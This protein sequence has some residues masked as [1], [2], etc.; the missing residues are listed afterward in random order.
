M[1]A[2][3]AFAQ[4]PS[5]PPPILRLIRN[6]G[7]GGLMP[8]YAEA[9][10]AVE[11]IGMTAATGLL[12]TWFVELHQTFAGIESLDQ[13]LAPLPPGRGDDGLINPPRTMIA[14]FRP[15]W[16]Y[17]EDQAIRTPLRARYFHVSLIRIRPGTAADYGELV[18][19]RRQSQDSVNLDRPELAY[20]VIFGAPAETYVFL[21]PLVSLLS[22]DEGVASTP[23]YAEGIADARSKA[24]AKIAPDA[25]IS[26]ENLLFRVEP[27][28]SYVSDEF[29][30]ADPAFW[31]GKP[32]GQ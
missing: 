4:T 24:R 8:R 2:A 10:A 6:P 26:R 28:L 1:L 16:S 17:R 22:L 27:R 5:D 11:S 32:G 25:E 15:A 13:A 18:N 19:L 23:P 3:C 21:A 12:E 14:Q 9:R 29:A 31:R 20:E 7:S 30:G